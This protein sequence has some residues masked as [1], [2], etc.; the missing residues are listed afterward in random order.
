MAILAFMAIMGNSVAPTAMS[1]F[2]QKF[3]DFGPKMIEPA[4]I[5]FYLFN[6]VFNVLFLMYWRTITRLRLRHK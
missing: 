6:V 4:Y 5:S 1:L 3:S 2:V